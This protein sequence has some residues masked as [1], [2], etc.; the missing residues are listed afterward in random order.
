[1]VSKLRT[2]AMISPRRRNLSSKKKMMKERR[3]R[4]IGTIQERYTWE[5]RE[6]S[7]PSFTTELLG[8]DQA[9]L[10]VIL[11]CVEYFSTQRWEH[12]L[13][14]VLWPMDTGMRS[15]WSSL[16]SIKG[17]VLDI[18]RSVPFPIA[19]AQI[20]TYLRIHLDLMWQWLLMLKRLYVWKVG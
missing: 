15:G 16:F 8:V 14:S 10:L 12:P 11:L 6:G 18:T 17:P 2:L 13:I 19:T 4:D 1:M 20:Q 7:I 5:M 9:W 3:G